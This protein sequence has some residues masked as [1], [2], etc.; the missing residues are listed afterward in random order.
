MIRTFPSAFRFSSLTDRKGGQQKRKKKRHPREGRETSIDAKRTPLGRKQKCGENNSKFSGLA[1]FN[2]D[3]MARTG[4]TAKDC[5]V[6][7]Q[8][9]VREVCFSSFKQC[10]AL[11]VN[12]HRKVSLSRTERTDTQS[13]LTGPLDGEYSSTTSRPA[14]SDF[15]WCHSYLSLKKL[16]VALIWSP[17]TQ[18]VIFP[19]WAPHMLGFFLM[20]EQDGRVLGLLSEGSLLLDASKLFLFNG[21]TK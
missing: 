12:A 8:E 4:N 10:C 3:N 6:L 19:C 21:A 5:A 18:P 9:I 2:F 15:V 17:N 20:E 7:F 13:S 14:A 1:E 11:S 16:S